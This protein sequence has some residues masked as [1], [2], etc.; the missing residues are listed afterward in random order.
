MLKHVF[1]FGKDHGLYLLG[2]L[3]PAVV[4]PGLDVQ[5]AEASLPGVLPVHHQHGDRVLF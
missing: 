2:G 5:E 4:P 1:F 3:H